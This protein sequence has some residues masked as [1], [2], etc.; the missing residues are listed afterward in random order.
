MAWFTKHTAM[1]SSS[2]LDLLLQLVELGPL[3]PD[4]E[5]HRGPDLHHPLAPLDVEDLAAL[6]EKLPLHPDNV[7]QLD[8]LQGPIQ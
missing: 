6:A 2:I 1:I 5:A 7:S 4:H 3:P 8:E